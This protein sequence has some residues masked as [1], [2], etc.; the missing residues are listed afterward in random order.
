MNFVPQKGY[1]GS[2]CCLILLHATYNPKLKKEN[3]E[4]F[5]TFLNKEHISYCR[6]PLFYFHLLYIHK[7][8][9]SRN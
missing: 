1:T 5:L 4:I 2:A 8:C 7:V 3:V 6:F 9:K